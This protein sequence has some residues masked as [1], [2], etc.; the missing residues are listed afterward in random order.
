MYRAIQNNESVANLFRQGEKNNQRL[1]MLEIIYYDKNNPDKF[2]QRARPKNI[3]DSMDDKMHDHAVV[4]RKQERELKIQMEVM[5]NKV[6]DVIGRFELEQ[7]KNQK[8]SE[9][10]DFCVDECVELKKDNTTFKQDVSLKMDQLKNNVQNIDSALKRSLSLLEDDL[11]KT[12]LDLDLNTEIDR[13]QDG[14]ILEMSM[15]I[16]TIEK[17]VKHMELFKLEKEEYE[18]LREDLVAKVRSV[19]NAATD[20]NARIEATDNYIARYLP[21]NIFVQSLET[22]KVSQPQLSMDKKLRDTLMNYEKF[23]TKEL[24]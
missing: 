9:K 1:D 15:R 14:Q 21:L 4:C 10:V 17:M 20:V 12:R 6:E 3:F 8:S 22:A 13:K 16:D 7:I 2:D 11:R 24:Y 18:V 23:K 19:T 5:R